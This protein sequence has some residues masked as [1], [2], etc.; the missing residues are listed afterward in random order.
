MLV[1]ACPNGE[2]RSPE[3]VEKPSLYR[4][5]EYIVLPPKLKKYAMFT[6]VDG[7]SHHIACV[8]LN[9]KPDRVRKDPRVIRLLAAYQGANSP[10]PAGPAEIHI[11]ERFSYVMPEDVQ[12]AFYECARR[13]RRSM[14]NALPAD[15]EDPAL[16]RTAIIDFEGTRWVPDSEFTPGVP[17][18]ETA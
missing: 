14:A 4:L 16:T 7:R 15:P 10:A 18:G 6:L 13:I 11:P 5:P 12:A 1:W 9:L 17:D 2:K 8:L 3:T